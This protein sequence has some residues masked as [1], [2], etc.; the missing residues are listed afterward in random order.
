[1]FMDFP[2][3]LTTFDYQLVLTKEWGLVC[4]QQGTTTNE[5]F[6]IWA[7]IAEPARISLETHLFNVEAEVSIF[8]HR[9][10]GYLL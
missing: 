10:G 8:I 5:N 7:A 6:T 2:R 3:I 9:V 4:P 1:M